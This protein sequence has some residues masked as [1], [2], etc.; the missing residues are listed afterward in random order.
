[1]KSV[2]KTFAMGCVSMFPLA[3]HAQQAQDDREPSLQLEEIVVTAQR[4]SE[5][6]Q[7]VPITVSAFTSDALE[8]SN[9]TSTGDLQQVVPGFVFATNLTAALPTLRGVGNSTAGPSAESSVATYVD[10]VYYD[11]LAAAAFS[12]ANIDHIEVLK[13]PQGTLFGRNA[14]GGLVNVITKTPSQTPGGKISLGYANYNTAS[15][16]GYLTGGLTDNLAADIAFFI[17]DQGDGWGRNLTTGGDAY[18]AREQVVRSK[19]FLDLDKTRVTFAADWMKSVSDIGVN[20]R[21]LPG[22]R[23]ANG[24][25][26]VGGFYDIATNKP[27]RGEVTQSGASLRVEHDFGVV[28]FMSSSAYR[29]TQSD[30]IQDQ[31]ATP[32]PRLQVE[33]LTIKNEAFTQ[34]LQLSSAENS[35]VTWIVGAFYLDRRGAYEP[36]RL[37]A[38]G[39]I[40]GHQ[41]AHQDTESIS[42]YAQVTAPI[43]FV[44][45]RTKLTLGVRWT[46]DRER[47]DGQRLPPLAPCLAPACISTASNK[48]EEVTWRVA[49]NHQFTDDIMGYVTY[50]TGYKGGFYTLSALPAPVTEPEYLDAWEV[51]FKSFFFDRRLRLNSSFFYYD[52]SDIQVLSYRDGFTRTLNAARATVYGVDIDATARITDRLTLSGGLEWMPERSYDEFPNLPYFYPN[53]AGGNLGPTPI[54]GKG[55]DLQRSAELAVTGGVDYVAPLSSGAK[56]G[57][58]LSAS[59]LSETPLTLGNRLIQPAYTLVNAQ[60]RWT[61]P[62]ERIE[63]MLWGKNIFDEQHLKIGLESA[64]GDLVIVG[65]PATYGLQ[66]SYNF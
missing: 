51:G 27:N 59:Y 62:D 25:P 21:G 9:V 1:M 32:V 6:I 57:L 29:R 11:A 50:N 13:G 5:D 49:L 17:S 42:A 23:L 52:Y 31:D 30:L 44:S 28:R 43:S 45:D 20:L 64:A 38:F 37:T 54:N 24:A 39:N 48:Q 61:S 19:W 65:P 40:I 35:A 2:F 4:R 58:N 60:V 18:K 55:L 16:S 14:T 41:N 46:S 10:G 47:V 36:A 12:L 15:A 7:K 34:E 26:Q 33:N 56:L 66:V 53:P 8:R 63:V 22:V 3:A